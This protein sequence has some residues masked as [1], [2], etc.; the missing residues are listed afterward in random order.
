MPCCKKVKKLKKLYIIIEQILK[1][2]QQNQYFRD[3][4]AGQV[5][6]SNPLNLLPQY[7]RN[8]RANLGYVDNSTRTLSRPNT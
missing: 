6:I 4:I 3:T 2:L 1:T 8:Q 5:P 7:S